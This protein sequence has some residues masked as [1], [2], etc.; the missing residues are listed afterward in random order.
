MQT[1]QETLKKAG[2]GKLLRPP[3]GPPG[4]SS[5]GEATERASP[6]HVGKERE[7]GAK[8][9]GP[10]LGGES[11]GMLLNCAETSAQRASDHTKISAAVP[12]VPG[13]AGHPMPLRKSEA[14]AAAGAVVCGVLN[15]QGRR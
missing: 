13:G 8:K 3:G 7:K 14:S 4:T 6:E 1:L 15:I 10:G 12:A 9:A 11:R 5:A 2:A